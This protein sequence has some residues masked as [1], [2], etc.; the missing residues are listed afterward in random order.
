MMGRLW[1]ALVGCGHPH[2]VRERRKIDGVDDVLCFVC[3]ACGEAIPVVKRE[4]AEKW[5]VR[6][7]PPPPPRV[8]RGTPGEVVDIE[9][10]RRA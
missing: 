5:A 10:R 4:G 8:W 2:T 9:T 7:T 6:A 1:R 3:Q